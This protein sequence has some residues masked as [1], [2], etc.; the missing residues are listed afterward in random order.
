MK[1][2]KNKITKS[3]NCWAAAAAAAAAVQVH[4]I[5]IQ[6]SFH[7]N[8]SLH[9]FNMYILRNINMYSMLCLTKACPQCNQSKSVATTTNTIK[10]TFINII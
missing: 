4:I 2:E 8:F 7:D 9:T 3:N 10:R 1:E 6:C 5:I